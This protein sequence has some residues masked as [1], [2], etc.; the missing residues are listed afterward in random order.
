MQLYDINWKIAT[1]LFNSIK[2]ETSTAI[3]FLNMRAGMQIQTKQPA[4]PTRCLWH[5]IRR[6]HCFVW[7]C[8][9]VILYLKT[10]CRACFWFDG[11]G[12]TLITRFTT[13][14]ILLQLP[15]FTVML[16][17]MASMWNLIKEQQQ[18]Q[19]VLNLHTCI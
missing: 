13:M 6:A 15:N 5:L 19:K 1:L 10:Y 14:L 12:R 3:M 4:L 7:I 11:I 8:T 2:P 9:P 16:L 18:Q 17:Q